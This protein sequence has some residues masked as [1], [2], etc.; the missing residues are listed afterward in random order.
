M[1]KPHPHQA[2]W[3]EKK[4]IVMPPNEVVVVV[5]AVKWSTSDI[6]SY[7]INILHSIS[8]LFHLHTYTSTC[9]L[10]WIFVT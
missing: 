8:S 3:K 7:F 5:V 9:R 10:S 6:A 4:R 2:P 1:K